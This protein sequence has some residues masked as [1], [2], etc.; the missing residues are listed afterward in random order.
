MNVVV[1]TTK[2]NQHSQWVIWWLKYRASWGLEHQPPDPRPL[3]ANTLSGASL[4][5][6]RSRTEVTVSID[7]LK[8]SW[9]A[10]KYLL[11]VTLGR[12]TL[13]TL[14]GRYTL[15]LAWNVVLLSLITR[16]NWV[17]NTAN[18]CKAKLR[19][20][21]VLHWIIKSSAWISTWMP[22]GNG[23]QAIVSIIILKSMG[24]I[25]PLYGVFTVTV[26]C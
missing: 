24:L 10:P 4:G 12:R 21:E 11:L 15:L 16:L 23:H 19:S 26:C 25:M 9:W 7:F 8:L 22:C 14:S 3:L 17:H 1:L 20:L 13:F 6:H 5:T 18:C 2:L